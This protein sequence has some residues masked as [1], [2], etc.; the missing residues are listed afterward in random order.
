MM[1]L[2]N[3]LRDLTIIIFATWLSILHAE[4]LSTQI[5]DHVTLTNSSSQSVNLDFNLVD[6][7]RNILTDQNYSVDHFSIDGEGYTFEQGYPQLPAVTR[8]IVVPPDVGVDLFVQTSDPYRVETQNQPRINTHSSEHEI[9]AYIPPLVGIYPPVVAEISRPFIVRGVRMVRVVTYPV[10]WDTEANNYLKYENIKTEIRFTRDNPENPS[11]R[12]IRRNRSPEFLKFI[13]TFALNGN[14]VG[15]DDPDLD[16]EPEYVGHYLIVIHENCLPFVAPFIEWRRKSGWKVDI[17]SLTEDEA[18]DAD[19]VKENIQDRYDDY[20]EAGID[21]FDH[22]LLIGDYEN[23]MNIAPDAQWVL[24]APVGDAP[25]AVHPHY[26]WDYACLE[27]DDND[28][29]VGISR[30]VAGTPNI[31]Q[32][33][34][35]KT[36]NY[37]VTPYMENTDWFQRGA[38][39]SSKWSRTYHPSVATNVRWGRLVLESLG[40]QDLRVFE[41]MDEWD[42]G[43]FVT[44]FIV[45][46]YN[47]GVN[48]LIGRGQNR[49]FNHEFVG[50]NP[51]NVYPIH[52]NLAGH[53]ERPMW[54][55][56]RNVSADEPRG[57]V[58]STCGWGNPVTGIMNLLWLEVV[59]GF[60]V[61]DMT[62]GWSR[63][64]MLLGAENV[65]PNLLEIYPEAKIDNHHYGDPGL[66]YWKGV[67]KVVEVRCP[68]TLAT[69]DRLISVEVID[70]EI[71]EPVEGARV[72]LYY[73]RD[74]PDGENE[75]YAD[76]DEMFM[77]TK[78][79]D[80]EGII[81]FIL[82]EDIGLEPGRIFVTVSGREILPN[83]CEI[84]IVEPNIG[85]ELS[86]WNTLQIEG[87]DDEDINPGESFD[88]ILAARNLSD[89]DN[90]ENVIATV[91]SFSNFIEIAGNNEI[92]FGNI[93]AGSVVEGGEGIR[94]LFT[95]D[96]PDAASR[97]LT[98][99]SVQITFTSGETS[100]VTAVT[101]DPV[102]PNFIIRSVVGGDLIEAGNNDLNLEI[103]NIGRMVSEEINAI[104]VSRNMG[105]GIL[106]AESQ[107]PALD[108]GDIA[109]LD[110]RELFSIEGNQM[111]VPGSRFEVILMLETEG[112]FVDSAFTILQVGEARE[113]APQG[114]DGYGYICF[115]DT[116]EDWVLAPTYDW[117]EIC[118]RDDDREFDGIDIEEFDGR[119]E[120]DIGETAVIDLPF[121]TQFYG[122]TYDQITVCTNG[123]ISMGDQEYV[124]NFQNWPMDHAVGGGIGML[125]PLWDDLMYR[126]NVSSICCFFDEDESRFI[127]EWYRLTHRVGRDDLTFQVILYD[128][129]VWNTRTGDQNILF[130][131]KQ[132]SNIPGRNDG[133]LTSSPF[134]SVGISSPDGKTGINYSFANQRPITSSPLQNRRAL[135]FATSTVSRVGELSGVVTDADDNEPVEGAVVKMQ[136]GY[137]AVSDE[138]GNWRISNA[139]AEIEFRLTCSK[140]G[141]NDTTLL[142]LS[143]G[144]NEAL[145][146]NF[147]L[148]HPEFIPSVEGLE[149]ELRSGESIELPFEISNTGNGPLSWQAEERL[150]GESNTDIWD[151]RR[152]YRIGETL[153]DGRCLGAV[154]VDDQFYVAGSNDRDPQIYIL[155]REGELTGQ[156]AQFGPGGGNG[157]RD[158]GYDGEWI[159]GSGTREIYA[160]TPDGELM[161]EFDGPFNPNVNITWDLDREIIWT[162][163]ATSDIV[164]INREG[165]VIA[166]LNRMEMRVYGL[167]YWPDDPDGYPL[168]IFHR[169]ID[170]GDQIVTKLDPETN[171]T[172]FVSML[173]H[174]G[175]GVPS[176]AYCSDQYDQQCPVFMT[177]VNNGADDRLDIW[178]LDKKLSWFDV[179]PMAGVI[180]PDDTQ[181]FVLS[182]DAGGLEEGVLFE[183]NI[184]FYHNA[185]NGEFDLP[186]TLMVSGVNEPQVV[187]I[188]EGWSIISLN[189]V[190]D[191][192]DIRELMHQLVDVGILN[193]LKDG[194]GRFYFPEI[195]FCN[196]PTWDESGGY[197]IN[198]SEPS[199]WSVLGESIPEDQPI[200]LRQGWNMSAYFPR[201]AVNAESALAGIVDN[202]IIAKDGLGRFYLPELGFSNMGNLQVGQGYQYNIREAIELVYQIGEEVALADRKV[203]HPKHFEVVTPTGADMSILLTTDKQSS[204]L[205]LACFNSQG[206]L[207]G[208]GCFDI[209][210]RC[211]L[212]VWGDDEL[213]DIFDGAVEGDA[214]TFIL[215]DGVK[216][217]AVTP[218][219][220]NREYIWT[221]GGFLQSEISSEMEI[222]ATFGIHETYP[223]P[224]NGPVRLSFGLEVDAH[225]SLRVY[226]LSGRLVTTLVNGD[227]KTGN[228]KVLWDTDIVSSGLYIIKLVIPGRSHSEKIAVLK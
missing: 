196:I 126:N 167:A 102:A 168:Y 151:L 60:V 225:V 172:M 174:Q 221:A 204:L 1:M 68:E 119:S 20:L 118:P 152:D 176:A 73:P 82:P 41:N 97:P 148:L 39:Y 34:M 107:Y 55:M 70:P 53:Q 164:G 71:E 10:R 35:H 77:I 157:Y 64:K 40:W 202:L 50:V 149:T 194:L 150:P 28:A 155:N 21:P 86:E 212:A 163:T 106:E 198:L 201:Q 93:N 182:L 79:T 22:I 179:E 207:I 74:L 67:P 162:S 141:Y 96:C 161:C 131:Y 223:N 173:D 43:A 47:D 89:E 160:F 44:P 139:V 98:Q 80:I 111:A 181:D 65:I 99:P 117:V 215:W 91:T 75:N 95:S 187:Q 31:L 222:P 36:M 88:L 51:G 115:D 94:L 200:A 37:E 29:D 156:F 132:V 158:L 66:Q 113:N 2:K 228:H 121:E 103:E 134:A 58:A 18:A 8:V 104:L 4:D 24:T 13:R 11:H 61:H 125:A 142:D 112:G 27:G 145:E 185:V 210:G 108:P 213:T 199:Q 165:D 146:I 3:P 166:N 140:Q 17:L 26:D 124:T 220:V 62:F 69:S 52:M 211:G 42:Q 87:N 219:P 59:S 123:F 128:R 92:E 197:L 54:T 109:R 57:P 116:D 188:R 191:N 224:T 16:Q 130:Q 227:Y 105:I 101:L 120:Y 214:L 45:E 78:K 114:P 81:R 14:E 7:E 5:V 154:F 144:E 177:V 137:S 169:T 133:Y 9:I 76:Y 159:W 83:F 32:L 127:V 49:R 171:D 178:Q 46:Q 209:E 15:R 205:E 19:I 30:W 170:V 216:E 12:P 193:F 100:W 143:V 23:Y 186:V 192:P 190:P 203:V 110:E 38:I 6:V 136:P 175:G 25:E 63:L 56:L 129:E 48:L 189:V 184:R 135:L 147:N 122:R 226:D 72:T 33:F 183:A 138:E 90:L 85:V 206:L 218:A 195:N 84:D 180:N 208:S 217:I 153:G